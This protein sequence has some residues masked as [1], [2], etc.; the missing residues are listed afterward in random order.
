MRGYANSGESI[1]Q[2]WVQLW[3]KKCICVE[4]LRSSV[5]D[6]WEEEMS[7]KFLKNLKGEKRERVSREW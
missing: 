6:V 2:T 4:S 5:D 1:A 7:M 3:M